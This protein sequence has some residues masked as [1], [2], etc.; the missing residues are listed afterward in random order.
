MRDT[1]R[2]GLMSLPGH[3]PH[4]PHPLAAPLPQPSLPESC[5]MTTSILI[6]S[7]S[8]A[9][10]ERVVSGPSRLRSSNDLFLPFKK[11]KKKRK[12]FELLIPH[13]F[14]FSFRDKSSHSA[15]F[16]SYLPALSFSFDLS[17]RSCP[18][19]P[20]PPLSDCFS[21]GSHS[22]SATFQPAAAT[23]GCFVSLLPFYHLH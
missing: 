16:T 18:P 6:T 21:S 23:A 17:L 19:P 8:Q 12:N 10:E 1:W 14:H 11:K 5:L 2:A 13:A 4:P 22:G 9:A 15:L 7:L 3:P 20:S